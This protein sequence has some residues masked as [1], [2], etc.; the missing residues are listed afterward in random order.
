MKEEHNM[1]KALFALLIPAFITVVAIGQ[2]SATAP[3]TRPA[4]LRQDVSVDEF[5]KLY[6]EK[7]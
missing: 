7:K 6:N 1:L 2:T 4:K 5:E 3:A